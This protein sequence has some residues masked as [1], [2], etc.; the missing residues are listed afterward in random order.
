MSDID[1]IWSELFAKGI[2]PGITDDILHRLLIKPARVQRAFLLR[3]R[4]MTRCAIAFELGV[5]DV[6]IG[7]WLRGCCDI[8]EILQQSCGVDSKT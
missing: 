3:C 4:G 2:D 8:K 1:L 7:K 5:S 6:T